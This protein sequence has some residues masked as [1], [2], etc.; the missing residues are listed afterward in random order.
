LFVRNVRVGQGA[1]ASVT[2]LGVGAWGDGM[3]GGQSTPG[4]VT[5]PTEACAAPSLGRFT[6]GGKQLR[7]SD[8]VKVTRGLTIQDALVGIGTG[9]Y[10]N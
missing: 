9:K 4:T 5:Y 7:I 2:G 8:G 10:N 3:A 1:F 6:G